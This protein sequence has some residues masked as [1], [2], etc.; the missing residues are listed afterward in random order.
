MDFG[1]RK[2]STR[3]GNCNIIISGEGEDR[4]VGGVLRR[5]ESGR[6][7]ALGSFP[8]K[9]GMLGAQ[10]QAAERILGTE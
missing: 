5:R 7:R 10:S 3:H 6:E 2:P 8:S 1:K 9:G 4:A